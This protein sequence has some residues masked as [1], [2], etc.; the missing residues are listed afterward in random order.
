MN[1]HICLYSAYNHI[2]P[3]GL[4]SHNGG[5]LDIPKLLEQM[6]RTE[7]AR[8][9]TE[10]LLIDLRRQVSDLTKSQSRSNEK[11]KDQAADIKSLT[12]KLVDAEQNLRE[13]T[14]SWALRLCTLQVAYTYC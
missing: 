11:V 5:V 8:E 12:R 7:K 9:D 1:F 2:Y 14:V 13:I 3:A 4:V 10:Q 6:R